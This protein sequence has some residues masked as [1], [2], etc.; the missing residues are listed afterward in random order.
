MKKILDEPEIYNL[1]YSLPLGNQFERLK[2]MQWRD[3]ERERQQDKVIFLTKYN[4]N[5]NAGP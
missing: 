1:T 5:H 2:A 4:I 3:A